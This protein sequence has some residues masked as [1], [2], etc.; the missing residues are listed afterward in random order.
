[1]LREAIVVMRPQEAGVGVGRREWRGGSGGGEVEGA[2]K[3]IV[4]EKIAR[5]AWA[6][7]E[8]L[9]RISAQRKLACA[10]ET[11]WRRHSRTRRG[12]SAAGDWT[13]REVGACVQRRLRMYWYLHRKIRQHRSWYSYVHPHRQNR[14]GGVRV[15]GGGG[16]DG[17]ARGRV[18]GWVQGSA[19]SV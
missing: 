6:E 17:G 16:G 9:G 11:M 4:P 10:T 3:V 1:M 13:A 2:K 14:N 18:R 19:A 15:W 7:K 12:S 8:T 5:T